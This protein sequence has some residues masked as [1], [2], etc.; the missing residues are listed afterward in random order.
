MASSTKDNGIC[1]RS[2]AIKLDAISPAFKNYGTDGIII[3]SDLY[4]SWTESQW[5]GVSGRM[6]VMPSSVQQWATLITGL[7]VLIV[8]FFVVYFL[9]IKS[10]M[11]FISNNDI[12]P[13]QTLS[14]GC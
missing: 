4:S 13:Q 8:S 12:V 9:N 5:K 3:D 2:Q 11:L 14:V 1:V 10:S 7:I 6:F